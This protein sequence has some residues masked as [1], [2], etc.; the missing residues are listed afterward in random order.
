MDNGFAD[1]L[2]PGKFLHG[3][4]FGPVLEDGPSSI[5]SAS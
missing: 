2:V 4:E 1:W 5:P 3:L